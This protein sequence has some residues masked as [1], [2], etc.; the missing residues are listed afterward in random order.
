MMREDGILLLGQVRS[1]N[2]DRVGAAR[3][4]ELH[5]IQ[6]SLHHDYEAAVAARGPVKIQYH[7][8]FR[9]RYES[10]FL[11]RNCSGAYKEWSTKAV[12]DAIL[13][14]PLFPRLLNGDLIRDT[15][16]RGVS[17]SVLAYVGKDNNGHYNP[18]VFGA[19]MSPQ[20]VATVHPG[21][22]TARSSSRQAS[23]AL[24]IPEPAA[25]MAAGSPTR[26]SVARFP[27]ES[28][29]HDCPALAHNE[30]VSPEARV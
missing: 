2:R 6:R 1:K 4:V 18:F 15:V 5:A 14:S 9:R 10:G 16:A 21:L 25:P 19:S 12:K 30:R 28:L 23:R 3:L 26:F 8:I 11:T 20:E 7:P 27:A 13:A 17:N 24:R 22:A 29:A